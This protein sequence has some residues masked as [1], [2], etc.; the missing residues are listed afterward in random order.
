MGF[1]SGVAETGAE[2][3]DVSTVV[4]GIT[5]AATDGGPD[6]FI[7]GVTVEEVERIETELEDGDRVQWD[8]VGIEE[9]NG[10]VLVT[11]LFGTGRTAPA[12]RLTE[13]VVDL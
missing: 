5:V 3:G 2:T 4:A 12:L 11:L 13:D 6:V 8:T 7:V 10:S 9:G 1:R